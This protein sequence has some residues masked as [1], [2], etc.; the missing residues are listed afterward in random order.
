MLK[1][2]F[3]WGATSLTFPLFKAKFCQNVLKT[4]EML[5]MFDLIFEKVLKTG[6][7]LKMLKMLKF[8]GKPQDTNSNI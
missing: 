6:E 7:M 5:K 8:L 3:L 1:I 2:V 4:G